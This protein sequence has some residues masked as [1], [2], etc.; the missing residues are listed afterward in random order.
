MFRFHI[1]VFA[2]L[3]RIGLIT[4]FTDRAF[5]Q[6][7]SSNVLAFSAELNSVVFFKG[8][9][10]KLSPYDFHRRPILIVQIHNCIIFPFINGR[11]FKALP[12]Q[13]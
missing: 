3:F 5:S 4:E 6:E 8:W 12:N 2:F 1:I 9:N 11:I 7:W 10:R 13:A